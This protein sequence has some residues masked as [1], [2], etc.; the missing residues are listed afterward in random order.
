MCHLLS[1]MHAFR[2]A[3]GHGGFIYIRP[4]VKHGHLVMQI[5]GLLNGAAKG[6][7]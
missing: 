5:V 4:I 3:I 7:A 1:S 6:M 2:C